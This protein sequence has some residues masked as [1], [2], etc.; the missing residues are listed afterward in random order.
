VSQFPA[1]KMPENEQE[2]VVEDAA[3]RGDQG[4]VG[5]LGFSSGGRSS[6][7]GVSDPELVEKASRRRY[8]AKYKL[9][10]VR[11]ADACTKPGEVGALLRREGLYSSHLGTWRAQR[12][13]GARVRLSPERSRRVLTVQA[14]MFCSAPVASSQVWRTSRGVR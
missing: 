6:R 13:A 5:E 14:A 4:A 10:I 1:G 3:G 9:S 12:D 8:S 11:E 2:P 7:E